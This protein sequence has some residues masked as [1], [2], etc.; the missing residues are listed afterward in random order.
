[1]R[2]VTTKFPGTNIN[3]FTTEDLYAQLRNGLC[4][5]DE[6]NDDSIL[7]PTINNCTERRFP[8]YQCKNNCPGGKL[9]KLFHP[10]LSSY[11]SQ[12]PHCCNRYSSGVHS[13]NSCSVSS[14]GVRSCGRSGG[15]RSGRC[16]D[17]DNVPGSCGVQDSTRTVLCS[18]VLQWKT[19]MSIKLLNTFLLNLFLHIILHIMIINFA[20]Y[21]ISMF[22]A[23]TTNILRTP[24]ITHEP[25]F[26]LYEIPA[27]VQFSCSNVFTISTNAL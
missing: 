3:S 8:F 16:T 12:L 25:N 5:L 24:S 20:E 18:G 10:V 4:P 19:H 17:S 6:D 7:D 27:F 22:N 14:A 11:F 1:M 15:F 23:L 26:P 9:R 2:N 21:Y 13:R